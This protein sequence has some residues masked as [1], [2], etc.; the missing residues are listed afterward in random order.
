MDEIDK[1]RGEW[2]SLERVLSTLEE[3][4]ESYPLDPDTNRACYQVQRLVDKAEERHF[5]AAMQRARDRAAVA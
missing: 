2:L 3:L 1:R 5:D 4:R